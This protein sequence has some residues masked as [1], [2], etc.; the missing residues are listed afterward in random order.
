MW[1]GL[2]MGIN[3][4]CDCR[5][6]GDPQF[7]LHAEAGC[8][9]GGVAKTGK[10]SRSSEDCKRG[11]CGR[12]KYSKDNKCDALAVLNNKTGCHFCQQSIGPMSIRDDPKHV[13]EHFPKCSRLNGLQYGW[14]FC[15]Q[16][17]R[18]EFVQTKKWTMWSPTRIYSTLQRSSDDNDLQ[19]EGEDSEGGDKQP[20]NSLASAGP[21][22]GA[23]APRSK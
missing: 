21:A 12:C 23:K 7:Y 20:D 6:P 5:P 2:P 19:P 3:N 8:C 15:R 1:P 13:S 16:L 4:F 22:D 11:G 14:C 18:D 9:R 10:R 17:M